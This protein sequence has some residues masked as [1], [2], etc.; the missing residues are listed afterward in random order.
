MIFLT[1]KKIPKRSEMERLVF[2]FKEYQYVNISVDKERYIY[3]DIS[4]SF[5]DTAKIRKERSN[6]EGYAKKFAI[7]PEFVYY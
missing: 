3:T 2:S 7:K 6:L 4:Q 1:R 5:F